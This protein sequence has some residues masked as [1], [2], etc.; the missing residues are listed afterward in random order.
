MK[1]LTHIVYFLSS[2]PCLCMTGVLGLHQSDRSEHVG[3]F[4]AGDR[5]RDQKTM[6]HFNGSR[7]GAGRSA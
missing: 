5:G 2:M 1:C 3:K 6:G 7:N 4:D